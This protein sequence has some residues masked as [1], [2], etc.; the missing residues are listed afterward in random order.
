MAAWLAQFEGCAGGH[1][2]Q[3][4][5]IPNML[6][7]RVHQLGHPEPKVREAKW[8]NENGV[9]W[10]YIDPGKPQQN[11]FL[12][13]FNGSLRDAC[14]NG[15]IFDSL[16]NACRKLTLWRC[17]QDNVRPHCLPGNKTPSDARRALERSE[18]PAPDA[19]AQPQAHHHQPQGLSS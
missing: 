15:E 2:L 6:R 1:N 11:G 9:E 4:R 10:H 12:E 3:Q 18:G 14:L 13:S 16:A 19:L 17:D 7:H 5:V 8:T